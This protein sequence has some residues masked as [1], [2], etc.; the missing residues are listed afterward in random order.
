MHE[1]REAPTSAAYYPAA[2]F[3]FRFV[4]MELWQ[5]ASSFLQ[6]SSSVTFL[7]EPDEN[8]PR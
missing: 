6:A 8:A 7:A 2:E 3:Q 5:I 4:R 1:G